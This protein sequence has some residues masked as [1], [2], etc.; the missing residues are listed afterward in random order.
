MRVKLNPLLNPMWVA[1]ASLC[2]AACGGGG[3][4]DMAS[5][6]AAASPPAATPPPAPAPPPPTAA[7]PTPF[8][9]FVKAQVALA[10]ETLDPA[11]VN[12][13]EWIFDEEETAYDD[14]LQPAGG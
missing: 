3:G 1:A 2:L 8:T 4:S 13:Q 6:P 9:P 7:A 10:D 5:A 11:Q 14:I 12:D